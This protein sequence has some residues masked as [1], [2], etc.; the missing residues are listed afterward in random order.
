MAIKKTQS[1]QPKT[2][3]SS[4]S[5][6]QK[7]FVGTH[8]AALQTSSPKQGLATVLSKQSAE[9]KNN[10][11]H[12]R[13]AAKKLAIKFGNDPAP[14]YA[15]PA[16]HDGAKA[17]DL[18]RSL[19]EF[20]QLQLNDPLTEQKLQK[21]QHSKMFAKL[22]LTATDWQTNVNVLWNVFVDNMKCLNN[23]TNKCIKA[24]GY[25][26]RA[27]FDPKA[28]R[29]ILGQALCQ[30][31]QQ[32]FRDYLGLQN[33]VVKPAGDLL[34]SNLPAPAVLFPKL[35][36]DETKKELIVWCHQLIQQ[37]G[38]ERGAYIWGP[39]GVGKTY[40]AAV[41]ANFLAKPRDV[42]NNRIPATSCNKKVAFI[43]TIEL[44]VD[45]RRSFSED[46]APTTNSDAIA[47][48]DLLIIDD[49]G[50]EQSREWF[51]GEWL[52]R[53][54]SRRNRP[55]LVTIFLSNFNPSQLR[56]HYRTQINKNISDRLWS[57]IAGLVGDR[58]INVGSAIKPHAEAEE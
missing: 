53:L 13:V 5:K 7:N 12:L 21:M 25:H 15:T 57:R 35:I 55:G 34:N 43:S 48:V 20:A 38:H 47:N 22:P 31:H 28:R 26:L 1:R 56:T 2:D 11:A 58:V 33:F 16:M 18:P 10:N 46:Q 49:L 6:V 27:L 39:P 17:Y 51:A 40:I 45:L 44:L 36:H 24:N 37:F 42:T 3:Q 8:H 29:V 4:K 19:A 9:Q 14:Q 30:K 52:T 23:K 32:T 50:S 41:V 54:V